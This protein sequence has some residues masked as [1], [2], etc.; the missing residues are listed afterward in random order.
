MCDCVLTPILAFQVHLTVDCSPPEWPL[1]I[2]PG[3]PFMCEQAALLGHW[4]CSLPLDLLNQGEAERRVPFL[5]SP[6]SGMAF[7]KPG[8]LPNDLSNSEQATGTAG[9][10]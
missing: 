1:A 7:L 4:P 5:Q 9:Q 2:P 10:R 6:A 3:N 8:S